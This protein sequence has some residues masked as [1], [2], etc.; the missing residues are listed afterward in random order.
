MEEQII[1]KWTNAKSSPLVSTYV[2]GVSSVHHPIFKQPIE[3]L[4]KGLKV[5]GDY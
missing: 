2:M 4:P 5:N 1:P 3:E